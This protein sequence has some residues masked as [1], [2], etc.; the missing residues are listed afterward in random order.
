MSLL[1]E[2]LKKAEQDKLSLDPA[3]QAAGQ[4]AL[5]SLSEASAEETLPGY[6]PSSPSAS[7]RT[8]ELMQKEEPAPPRQS[9]DD[10]AR[11]QSA[12]ERKAAQNVFV[13]KQGGADGVRTGQLGKLW[14]VAGVVFI[15]IAGGAYYVWQEVTRAPGIGQLQV[16]GVPR[17]APIASPAPTTTVTTMQ[18]VPVAKEASAVAPSPM[19]DAATTEAKGQVVTSGSTLPLSQ[20]LKGTSEAVAR[21]P[22]RVR[23]ESPAAEPAAIRIQRKQSVNEVPPLLAAAYQ[24]YSAGDLGTARQ[25]YLKQL[26]SDPLSKDALL[27]LAAIAVHMQRSGEAKG[28]YLRILELDPRD[29]SAIAGMTGLGQQINPSQSQTE[30]RLKDLLTQQ[31]DAASLHFTLGN[32]YAS[33]SHWGEAQQAFFRAFSFDSTNADYAFNLAVSLD[34]LNQ[35][36]LAA[37]YYS[38]ALALVSVRPVGFDKAQAAMRL[39][40]LVR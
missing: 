29:P 40:E 32:H 15:A 1:L 38:R 33:Q 22:A 12:H 27:G 36:K 6:P 7:G 26:Q 25:Q 23:V 16:A 9:P 14:M 20:Y 39:K 4:A 21:S 18:T 13:A 8:L 17:A 31:P 28:Y 5:S 30:S 2:A 24:A 10:L 34:H 35:N 37:E 11:Q 3:R 19:K